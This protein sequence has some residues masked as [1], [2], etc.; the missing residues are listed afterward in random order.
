MEEVTHQAMAARRK[1][2][3][4]VK[5]LFTLSLFDSYILEKE[6]CGPKWVLKSTYEVMKVPHTYIWKHVPSL[7]MLTCLVCFK[8]KPV[9][10]NII[11]NICT[12]PWSIYKRGKNMLWKDVGSVSSIAGQKSGEGFYGK[13]PLGSIT[14]MAFL[15]TGVSLLWREMIHQNVQ[16]DEKFLTAM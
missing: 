15:L 9:K 5:H 8:Y 11:K 2:L 4:R 3:L 7:L 6:N 14:T 10:I 1:F 16:S 13:G 12:N